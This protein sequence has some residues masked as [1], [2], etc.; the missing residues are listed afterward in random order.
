MNS[1]PLELV[2]DGIIFENQSQG[3]ASRI[4][5]EILP[6]M[7][8]LEASL[9]ITLLLSGKSRKVLPV[10]P[11][12]K[13]QVFP[14]IERMIYPGRWFGWSIRPRLRSL[15]QRLGLEKLKHAIWHS[16]YYTLPT[17]W[18][19]PIVV[20]VLDMIHENFPN[21][22]DR[23]MDTQFRKQKQ[24]C[25]SV[26]DA[27]ICISESTRY[28]LLQ[29]YAVDANKT[30]VVPLA[31][32]EIFTVRRDSDKLD[33]PTSRPFLLYVGG[34]SHYKN[35]SLLLLA[36][37]AWPRHTDIDLVV[38]GNNWSKSEERQLAE[39]QI[40]ENVYLLHHI[41]D[42]DLCRLY[43]KA[44]ALVYPSLYEG[45]GIPVLEAMACGCPVI[46]S[47]IPTTVE[48]AS[49]VP[50]YFEPTEIESL[51]CALDDALSSTTRDNH[52]NIGLEHGKRYSWYKTA[53]KFLEVYHAQSA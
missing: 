50:L 19:G 16:T 32:S 53:K 42:K 41:E 4:Y 43:N 30:H 33:L 6:R 29:T 22:F 11:H 48:I 17:Q 49:D 34:R 1:N 15:V 47:R 21:L 23:Q 40:A 2:I 25:L 45:F 38:V 9:G 10:H 28:D 39:L 46:A 52:I 27:I 36:Y 12:I 8:E 24:R 37:A 26:A 14:P 3:G 31:A 51:H 5:S 44:L 35:F 20:T 18:N 7:C 13:R